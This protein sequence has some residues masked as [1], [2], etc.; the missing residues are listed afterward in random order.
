MSATDDLTAE[1]SLALGDAALVDE[2]P[3]EALA[4]YTAALTL[5]QASAAAADESSS[6]SSSLTQF[7]VL[8]HRSQAFYSLHRHAE[9]L[10][11][12]T[13]ADQLLGSKAIA[14]LRAGESEVLLRRQGR[15][16]WE[17]H[18]WERARTAF[19]KARQL[20]SLNQAK[21][22]EE[23]NKSAC[24]PFPYDEWIQ[25]C[26][27]QLTPP[28]SASSAAGAG[29][30]KVAS[31]DSNATTSSAST[32]PSAAKDPAAV[33]KKTI[34]AAAPKYQY[35]QSDK[36]MTISILEAGVQESDL[37][38]QFATDSI[39]VKLT[40]QQ[41]QGGA[42][43]RHEYTVVAGTLQEEVVPDQCRV[44]VRDE[45]V[46][47]KL[48]KASPGE[49]YE[50]LS[51]KKKKSK[52]GTTSTATSTAAATT[53]EATTPIPLETTDTPSTTTTAANSNS[54]SKPA[55]V[56]RPYASTRNWNAIEK[57]L[58]AEEEAE[59]PEGDDAMNKLF[60]SLYANADEDT[61]R[62]MIKSYQ[63]SG[64]TVLSTNW[65]E[66]KDKDYE[67]ER[68]APKGVEWKNWEG[69]KLPMTDDD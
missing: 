25:R 55:G 16:A 52:P 12:A 10:E 2:D 14:G 37:D 22:N 35:Y 17:L 50:L 8:S 54:N 18:Q 6:S 31:A 48:R 34:D 11:D 39:V 33:L 46:L 29:G 23:T 1:Q 15:A 36:V 20:A 3:E 13:A 49:W 47:I 24:T 40:K 21:Q 69:E 57:E 42:A 43:G 67:K 65:K 38:V 32:K 19:Q 5:L 9:A 62:A 4:A 63:T 51:S 41:Q 58:A 56:P 26:Q 27:K 68:S 61:R 44:Q 45:K 28:T 66:V 64:G 30:A 59:K 60:Q 7:R 53:M